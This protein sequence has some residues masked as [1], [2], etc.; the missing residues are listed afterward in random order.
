MNLQI[1]LLSGKYRWD[2]HPMAAEADMT[3]LVS[4]FPVVL[5]S[6]YLALL[7][8]SDGGEAELSGY[9]NYVRIWSARTAID[10]NQ[11]YNIGQVLPGF[12]A[13]GDNGGS[14]LV[15]F[16]TRFGQPHRVCAIPIVPMAWEDAL[17]DTVDFCTFIRQLLPQS[18]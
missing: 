10:Q 3:A 16:D 15:G 18:V 6:E 2:A 11:N 12:I 13:I 1:L 8:L 4:F 5:P 9:P 7:R 14:E 17:G